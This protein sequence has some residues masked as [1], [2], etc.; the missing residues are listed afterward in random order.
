M[1]FY[2]YNSIAE[3]LTTNDK[4]IGENSLINFSKITSLQNADGSSLIWIKNTSTTNEIKANTIICLE[5]EASNLKDLCAVI[6]TTTNPKLLFSKIANKLFVKKYDA[7]IHKTA[8]VAEDITIGKNCYIGANVSIGNNCTIGENCIIHSNVSIY[9]G[10]TIGRNVIIHSG[11]V[12]G[13]EGFGYSKDE[14]GEIEKFPHIG[15]VLIS[16]NVEIGANTCIDRGGLGNTVINEGVKIDNLVH[17]A[18]NV[19]IEKNCFIIANSMIGGSTH[20]GENSW[21]APSVSILQQLKIGK[22]VTVGVAAVVTK[23]I[24]DNETW[25]GTPAIKND[26]FKSRQAIL[27]KLFN[28]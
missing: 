8:S 20:I 6:I 25:M 23:S 15:G 2:T 16:D 26:I 10:V 9:D 1:K 22:N 18:H 4:I 13:A 11:A 14:N 27:N 19:V 21:I 7:G 24:P 28:K 17:I 5:S 3:L 12:I